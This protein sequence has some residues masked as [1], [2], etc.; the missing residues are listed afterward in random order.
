MNKELILAFFLMVGITTTQAWPRKGRSDDS[1]PTSF[2][3]EATN[4]LSTAILQGYVDDNKNL[5]F[6]PLG[7]AAIL[8]ILAEGAKG[9]TKQ[10]LTT[11][12]HL[13]QDQA[14]TRK[15]FKF[16]MERLKNT[17]KYE[18]NKPELK[19]WFYIYKNYTINEDYKKILEEY[20]LTEVK[21]V[22]RYTGY[23]SSKN[24]EEN[25]DSEPEINLNEPLPSVEIKDPIVSSI[26]ENDNSERKRENDKKLKAEEAKKIEEDLEEMKP[27]REATEKLISFA[28][29]DKPEKVEEIPYE[30]KPAKNIKEKIKLVK[31]Y[32]K[33]AEYFNDDEETMLAV[34]ARTHSRSLKVLFDDNQVSSSLSVNSVGKKKSKESNSLMI[35][36][37]GMYFRGSWKTP[38]RKPVPE[39]FYRSVK[40]KTQV[41]MMKTH[42]SFKT[43]S[44]PGL[45]S[46]AI[47]IPYS[48]GRYALLVIL[49]RARDGLNRLVAD[50]PG[51]PLSE[52]QSVLQ[53]KNVDVSIPSFYVET[54]T[55]PVAALAKFGVSSIFSPEADLSGISTN[56]GLFVQEMVQHVSVKVDNSGS[57][58][59]ELSVATLE[60]EAANLKNLP[61]TEEVPIKFSAGHPFVFFIHDVLD[62]LI[63][64]A[65]KVTDPDS[66]E[67]IA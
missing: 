54:T 20:Y 6:S 57:S 12:L 47:E 27:P 63:V 36:F 15:T 51:T 19:N 14:L 16:I 43:G 30:Y 48:D 46:T 44:L 52:F 55:K 35:M 65:G 4:E 7:Y 11:A 62:N 33:K 1:P 40:E 23:D 53:Y 29:E 42:G 37:N 66:A 24:S 58:Q 26:D 41:S 38:F 3:G 21:T 50:L 9:E 17:N 13:P 34:E 56:E 25:D 39:T 64:V 10:Q 28:V 31:V 60:E 5:A 59:S 18:V 49:P 61:L 22:E 2:V 45:D 8:A 67:S 32:P